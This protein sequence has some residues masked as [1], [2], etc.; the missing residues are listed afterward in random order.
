MGADLKIHSKT[1]KLKYFFMKLK[2]KKSVFLKICGCSCTH[3]THANEAP[4]SRVNSFKRKYV[5]VLVGVGAV[6]AAAP[7]DFEED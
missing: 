3:C 5:R 7:T 6:G 2:G 1:L 4:E